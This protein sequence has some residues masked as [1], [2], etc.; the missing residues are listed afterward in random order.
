VYKETLLFVGC[1]VDSI[2]QVNFTSLILDSESITLRLSV[3]STNTTIQL[4]WVLIILFFPL[5]YILLILFYLLIDRTS[6]F[7]TWSAV[8]VSLAW[9][10]WRSSSTRGWRMSALPLPVSLWCRFLPC[11]SRST[12]VR[13]GEMFLFLFSFFRS[14]FFVTLTHSQNLSTSLT[15]HLSSQCREWWNMLSV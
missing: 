4:V 13:L 3:N 6:L 11:P 9:W 15:T 8:R 12:Q 10:P 14:L 7:K 5:G 1:I 2:F